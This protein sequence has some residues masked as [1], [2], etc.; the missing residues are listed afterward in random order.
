VLAGIRY[1]TIDDRFSTSAGTTI[2]THHGSEWFASS[3]LEWRSKVRHE[4]S[5]LLAR[6]GASLASEGTPLLSWS[7]AG[8]GQ[9]RAELLRAHP[10]LHDG[11]IRDAVFGRGLV[12]GGVEWRRWAAPIKRVM[13]FGPALFVDTAR[14]Y[15]V[16]EYGDPRAHVDAGAGL[17]LAI[18]GAG[19]LRTDVA[20]GLRDGKWAFSVG[21]LR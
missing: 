17:R 6:A 3:S 16:P 10:L 20:V 7:G 5:V 8:A 1:Q 11:V 15:D 19:V 13:R 9:A 18:P 14:A 21:W 12:S 2:W 4:G